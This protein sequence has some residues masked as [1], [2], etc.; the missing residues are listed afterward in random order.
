MVLSC[1]SRGD[2]LILGI[3]EAGL[4]PHQ[5]NLHFPLKKIL[6]SSTAQTT[7]LKHRSI[8]ACSPS[9]ARPATGTHELPLLPPRRLLN[10]VH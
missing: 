3:P 5:Q 7:T 6:S 1:R 4:V 9:S 8:P 2:G 10:Q